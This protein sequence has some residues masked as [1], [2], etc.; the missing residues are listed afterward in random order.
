M[1]Y[2][3]VFLKKLSKPSEH[4]LLESK[5]PVIKEFAR[6]FYLDSVYRERFHGGW[7]ER[8]IY[9]LKLTHLERDVEVQ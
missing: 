5:G 9:L 4:L 2:L 3:L 1:F 8:N 7:T 6:L